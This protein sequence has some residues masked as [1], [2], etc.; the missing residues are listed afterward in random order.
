MSNNYEIG[1]CC[2][3]SEYV[4]PDR[5]LRPCHKC[6]IY[7]TI[8]HARCAIIDRDTDDYK[9]KKYKGDSPEDASSS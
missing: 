1:P 4:H 6:S 3:G 7:E 8:V 5:E 9:C 2:L